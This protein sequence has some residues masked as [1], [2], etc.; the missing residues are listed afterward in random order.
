[1]QGLVK[2]YKVLLVG[3][4]GCG[5]T[6]FV[7]RALTGQFEAR[8]IATLGVE[9]NPIRVSPSVVFNI[10]DCAGQEKFGGLREGYYKE[11]QAAIFA[12]D[13][14]DPNGFAKALVW[15]QNVNAATP[16][17]PCI[18]LGLKGD[19]NGAP[20]ERTRQLE[21]CQAIPGVD[22]FEASSKTGEGV[23]EALRG[24]LGLL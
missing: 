5:K 11:A 10:W 16:N 20:E 7:Q 4:G 2:T 12:F 3:E 18:L 24:L 19:I 6:A 13:M 22:Y 8:Y 17:L 23:K 15:T 14:T 9:V 1:M 21:V